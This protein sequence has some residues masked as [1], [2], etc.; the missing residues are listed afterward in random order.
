MILS[1]PVLLGDAVLYGWGIIIPAGCAA[2]LESDYTVRF[3]LV[4]IR[5]A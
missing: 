5:E 2:V 1:L 4:N 3:E